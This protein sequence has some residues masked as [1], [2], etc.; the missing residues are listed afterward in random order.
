M[1][2]SQQIDLWAWAFTEDIRIG[3]VGILAIFTAPL[4]WGF[5]FYHVYLIWAGMTTSESFKWDEW[6][7]DV[8]DGYVFKCMEP[9]KTTLSNGTIPRGDDPFIPWP[10]S[11]P[12]RLVSRANKLSLEMEPDAQLTLPPWEPVHHL[13]QI[14]NI[15]DLGFWDNLKD[16]FRLS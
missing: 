9:K 11:S 16:V 8:A 2:F 10:V 14:I 1:P 15:Y 3:A 4:A 5:L 13:S 6:K 12:Q 7:E